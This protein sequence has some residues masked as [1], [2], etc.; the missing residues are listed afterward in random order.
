MKMGWLSA[1]KPKAPQRGVVG[2][3]D[4]QTVDVDQFWADAWAELSQRQHKLSQRLKL[5]DARWSVDQN[6]GL[7]QF[8]RRDGVLINAPVQIIGALNPRNDSF[9]WGWDHP[10]VKVRLRAFAERTRWFG[11]RHNLNELTE[12]VVKM[13][14]ADAWRLTAVAVKV[15]AAM[16]AYRAPTGGP[17]IFMTIGEPTIL[18]GH[19]KP[20][21]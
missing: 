13:S 4:G 11:D 3:W 9:T 7:I 6:T 2:P 12:P 10:S 20:H 19:A 16:G 21:A 5:A 17:V 8:E 18:N 15:N 14:E 1:F